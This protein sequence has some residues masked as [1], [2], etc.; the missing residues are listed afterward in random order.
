MRSY[1]CRLG[2]RPGWA[3]L[4]LGVAAAA[5]AAGELLAQAPATPAP[6]APAPAA[7]AVAAP[8]APAVKAFRRWTYDEKLKRGALTVTRQLAGTETN[9]ALLPA[10]DE[11]YEKYLIGR[12]TEPGNQ[13]NLPKF[14]GDLRRDLVNAKTPAIRD[15]LLGVT[16][17]LMTEAA[18][19]NDFDPIVRVNAMLLIGE[20]NGEEPSKLNAPPVPYAAAIPTLTRAVRD[21]NLID[22]VKV[23]ALAGLLRHARIGIPAQQAAE[24]SAAM[25][26]VIRTK[27]PPTRSAAGHA[28]LRARAVDVLG[29]Q[30]NVG[31]ANAVADL[32]ADLA[33]DASNPLFLRRSA[34][35]ALG[36]L[37]YQGAANLNTDKLATA[38]ASVAV[39]SVEGAAREQEAKKTNVYRGMKSAVYAASAGAAAVAGAAKGGKAPQVQAKLQ[40]VVAAVEKTNDDTAV[41]AAMSQ[42][43]ELK[44]LAAAP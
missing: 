39:A 17:R 14:R 15:R 11:Y 10:F 21:A 33:A 41:A 6:S 28:W 25:L 19:A 18:F 16:M 43:A 44:S 37:N 13:V 40:Q 20:L 9:P 36:N 23:A 12:W 29:A 8:A 35:E 2:C 3:L 7:P 38:L 24:V 26:E 42:L 32:L 27:A 31:A 5:I 34:A 22:P 1:A 30:A 4:A